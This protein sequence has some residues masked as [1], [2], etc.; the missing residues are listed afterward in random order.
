[1]SPQTDIVLPC[2]GGVLAEMLGL[3]VLLGSLGPVGLDFG[4]SSGS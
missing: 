3:R 4:G 2:I 1:M